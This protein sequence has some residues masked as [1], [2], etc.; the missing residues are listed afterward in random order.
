MGCDIHEEMAPAISMSAWDL[1]VDGVTVVWLVVFVVGL[2]FEEWSS[3]C[4]TI[5]LLLLPVFIADLGVRY[6]RVRDLREFLTKHW[7][8]IVIV[9]PLLQVLKAL[10]DSENYEAH[11]DKQNR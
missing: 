6:W 10:K 5:N 1:F 8:D 3:F 2:A 9:I 11:Q 7:F 4:D